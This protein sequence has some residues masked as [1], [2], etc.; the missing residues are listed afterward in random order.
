MGTME[1]HERKMEKV[2][3]IPPPRRGRKEKGLER[4]RA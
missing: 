1:K 2:G 3:N 4:L